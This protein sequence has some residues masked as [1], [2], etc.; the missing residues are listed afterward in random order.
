[1]G[2]V[3]AARQLEVAIDTVATVDQDGY[4]PLHW[5]LFG[6]ALVVGTGHVQHPLSPRRGSYPASAAG[7]GGGG[8]GGGEDEEEHGED[9]RSGFGKGNNA[10]NR[11]TWSDVVQGARNGLARFASPLASSRWQVRQRL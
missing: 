9:G 4:R 8:G 3:E 6:K 11:N 7:M 1:G 10:A 5:L 2:R